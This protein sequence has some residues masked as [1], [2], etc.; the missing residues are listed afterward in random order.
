MSQF[1][2][3]YNNRFSCLL[4]FVFTLVGSR[5]FLH[6]E[7]SQKYPTFRLVAAF[8]IAC[9][10]SLIGAR[11]GA[12]QSTGLPVLV[13]N[14]EVFLRCGEEREVS[15]RPW[16]LKSSATSCIPIGKSYNFESLVAL[17]QANCSQSIIENVNRMT[18]SI[19]CA[20]DCGSGCSREAHE[21]RF[22]LQILSFESSYSEGKECVSVTC[23]PLPPP[24]RSDY[25]LL[26]PVSCSPPS[27]DDKNSAASVS[28]D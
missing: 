2:L 19:Q 12:A 7:G 8:L 28:L 15:F 13:P 23:Q 1:L 16:G 11:P 10:A 18:N 22:V 27:C 4:V 9:G 17:T 5:R 25:Q 6:M 26:V 24:G 14:S 20:S 3:G 21:L